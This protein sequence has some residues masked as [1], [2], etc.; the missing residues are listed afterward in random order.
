MD[1]DLKTTPAAPPEA[2]DN[3]TKTPRRRRK[4]RPWW[5]RLLKWLGITIV[6]LVLLLFMLV[7]LAVWILTP[8]RLTPLVEKYATEYLDG[9]MKVKRVELTYWSTFPNLYLDVDSLEIISHS[10][11]G[12]TPAQRDSLPAASD[13]LLRVESFNGGINILK[14]LTATIAL[15]DITIT[16]PEINIVEV[17]PDVANYNIFPRSE[18][19]DTT[20]TPIPDFSIQRFA[21]VGDAP[22]HYFSAAAD[23]DVRLT[24]SSTEISGSEAPSYRLDVR[25][26][27]SSHLAGITLNGL[28]LGMGGSIEWNRKNPYRI[29]FNDFEAGVNDVNT[30]ISTAVDFRDE[31]TVESLNFTLPMV[32]VNS[33]IALVPPEFR[34]EAA[35]I[36]NNLEV[37]MSARLTKPYVPSRNGVPSLHVDV[38]VPEGSASYEKLQLSSLGFELTADINGDNLN[39]SVVELKH[40]RAIGQGAGFELNA[41]VTDVMRDPL[42]KGSFRGGVEIDRLP[43]RLFTPLGLTARG[44]LRADADFEFRPSYFDRNNFHRIR[45]DGHATLNGMHVDMPDMPASAFVNH[46]E[47]ALGSSSTVER[48]GHAVD[49]LLTVSFAI[50]T[51][52]VAMPG[53]EAQGAGMRIGL[54]SRNVA[55]SIDTAIVNP[56]GGT[57]ELRRFNLLATDDSTR[58]RLRDVNLHASLTRYKQ[59]ARVPRLDMSLKAR[60]MRYSDA[61][62]RAS[63][64]ESD[65]QLTV[66]PTP[67]RLGRRMQAAIDSINRV[68]PGLPPD[69]VY[70]MARRAVPRRKHKANTGADSTARVDFELDKETRSLLRQWRASGHLKAA[71][72]RV[73]T[74]YFPLRNVLTD[75]DLT[76]NNDSVTISRTRWRVGHSDFMI[77]GSITNLTRALTS[78]SGRQPLRLNFRV[79]SDTL[80]VN[81]LAAAVFAGAAFAERERQG[82]AGPIAD[83]DDDEAIQASI[84]AAADTTQA[85]PLLIPVNIEASVR[86]AAR[87]VFYSD[88]AFSNF[89]GQAEIFD[90]ALN[91]RNLSARADVGAIDLTALYQG[92]HPDSLSFAFG[93]QVR[94]FRLGKFM[95]LVPSLDTIMPLLH[96]IKGIINAEVAASTRLEPTMDFVIPSLEAAV[97]ISG[98]S[99]VLLDAETFRKIGKWLLFKHKDRNVI[100]H[101]DARLVVKDSQMQLYPF[102][103]NVDRYKLGVF[104][105]N[106]MAMNFKY[107]VS[108]LK[109]PIP[110]KFGIN[111]SGNPDKM[112]IRLGGA[113]V[114]P[115]TAMT[116]AISDT[117]RINLV[118]RI[119]D[120]FRRGVRTAAGHGALHID[121]SAPSRVPDLDATA[122]D[123][124][125]SADSLI[126]IQEGLLPAPPKPDTTAT[127]VPDKT[128]K[129]KKKK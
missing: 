52:A 107:H 125:S 68:H 102:I 122:G 96:D 61:F 92:L 76:F 74:P 114:K 128:K 103:F 9:E 36:T 55:S 113:K 83:G 121:T 78:R 105:T 33:L 65:I 22:I 90:G 6:T 123:T 17:S 27:A 71:R 26:N 42:V 129:K 69:S 84:A 51:M 47:L 115:E 18:E 28:R 86:V 91:L 60:R 34:G 109:S 70:N 100:E 20:S 66:F 31:L 73:F 4:R 111:L 108:V 45:L 98:D 119:Q 54:G 56:I 88:L 99:L 87:N 62:N 16:R 24:L 15:R 58:I 93:M 82:L 94:D 29:A 101:M 30:V 64:K 104:G 13:T 127:S 49:S 25:G 12:I 37:T 32:K 41:K 79:V 10:L 67:P 2:P 95:Q 46:A 57:F 3:Q 50:D 120:I 43:S 117:T 112:K 21:I 126:F 1:N 110:F 77:D 11:R 44:S 14:L 5:V 81:E 118:N 7:G 38:E 116:T 63:L 35:H 97:S 75:I 23:V 48:A 80:D 85:G 89:R 19:E 106:D 72:A 59:M 53:L 124:I 39:A 40:F 8:E